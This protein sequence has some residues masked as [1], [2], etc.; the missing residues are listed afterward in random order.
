MK[1]MAF[2]KKSTGWQ[3]LA[4]SRDWALVLAIVA[5]FMGTGL[6][7]IVR[8]GLE[9]GAIISSLVGAVIGMLPS[10]LLCLPVRGRVSSLSKS[11]SVAAITDLRFRFDAERDGTAIY[12]DNSPRWMRWDSNRV[13]LR[14]SQDGEWE[15]TVPIHVFRILKKK[16]LRTI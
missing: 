8:V 9:R 3:A 6:F 15:A 2:E 11:Q 13:T 4:S 16:A 12:T 10:I 14:K 1:T 7:L 5:G